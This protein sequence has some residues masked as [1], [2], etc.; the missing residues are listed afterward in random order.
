MLEALAGPELLELAY[1]A[2]ETNG[3]RWHEF[4]DMHLILP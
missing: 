1:Q 2:A 4:G 3:Y